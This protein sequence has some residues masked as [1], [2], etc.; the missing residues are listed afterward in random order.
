[1]CSIGSGLSFW[2]PLA[3][4]LSLRLRSVVVAASKLASGDPTV[5]L[6]CQRAV[7]NR[8]IKKDGDL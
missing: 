7:S 8:Q 3:S 6:A 4:P 1:M 5:A 2:L